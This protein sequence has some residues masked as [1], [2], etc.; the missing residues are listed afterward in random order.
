MSSFICQ[1]SLLMITFDGFLGNQ[2]SGI[3]VV[4]WGGLRGVPW[5]GCKDLGRFNSACCIISSSCFCSLLGKKTFW[6]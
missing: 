4:G 6:L 1:V 5:A 3:S 2:G